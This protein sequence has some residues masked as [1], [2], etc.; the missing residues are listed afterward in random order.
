MNTIFYI[1]VS[2]VFPGG[3]FTN[4]MIYSR[5][6]MTL[7]ARYR[8][9]IRSLPTHIKLQLKRIVHLLSELPIL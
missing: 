2:L 3:H 8:Y 7:N 1:I 9:I 6:K 5:F 4:L